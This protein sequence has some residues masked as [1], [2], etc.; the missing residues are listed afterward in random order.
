MSV[1]VTVYRT[2]WC[3][4]CQRAEALLRNK[5]A[6][7][8]ELIDVDTVPGARARMVELAGRTS[9]PQIFIGDTHIGGCDELVALERE[10]RLDS[11]LAS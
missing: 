10:G 3:P 1:N 4:Y 6:A 5:P 7:A 9:V 2:D 11:M 8:V